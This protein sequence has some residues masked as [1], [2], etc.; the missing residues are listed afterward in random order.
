METRLA[1]EVR[2][3]NAEV[4]KQMKLLHTSLLPDLQS[5]IAQTPQGPGASQPAPGMGGL[6]EREHLQQQL[7][8]LVASECPLTGE[9]MIDTITMPFISE[10]EEAESGEWELGAP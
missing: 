2:E 1:N 3:G 4:L 9:S 5:L 8:D 10:E 7:D 6:T